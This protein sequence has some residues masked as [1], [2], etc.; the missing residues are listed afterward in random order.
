[1]PLTPSLRRELTEALAIIYP[2][3]LRDACQET[4]LPK[5]AFPSSSPLTIEEILSQEFF[6]E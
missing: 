6:P 5:T 2:K 3:A 4:G 1:M